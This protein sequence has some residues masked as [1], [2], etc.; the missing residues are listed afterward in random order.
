MKVK[1]V[2][3]N[4]TQY[5]EVFGEVFELGNP[6]SIDHLSPEVQ[7]KLQGNPM[8]VTVDDDAEADSAKPMVLTPQGPAP[9]PPAA[10]EVQI[11]DNWEGLDFMSL[12]ALAKKLDPSLA[13]D[14]VKDACVEVVEAELGKRAAKAVN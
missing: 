5:T 13:N 1:Y 9:A 3:D 12:K 7:A 11:P 8:F 2:G 4:F 10:M 14:A 6:K